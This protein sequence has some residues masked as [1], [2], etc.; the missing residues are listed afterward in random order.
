MIIIVY[1]PVASNHGVV[2]VVEETL[3]DALAKMGVLDASR[4][5]NPHIADADV[6]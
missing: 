5:S 4:I 1:D 2:E 6:S 3:I